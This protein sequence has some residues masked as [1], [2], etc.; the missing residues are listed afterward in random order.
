MASNGLLALLM[1]T[2][3][4]NEPVFNFNRYSANK[5]PGFSAKNTV[6]CSVHFTD[7]QLSFAGISWDVLLGNL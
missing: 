1:F 2:N 3:F 6:H 4:F 7:D 5:L